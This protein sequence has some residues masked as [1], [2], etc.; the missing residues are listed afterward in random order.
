MRSLWPL[1]WRLRLACIESSAVPD[2]PNS[3]KQ[4]APQISALEPAAKL[5][6]HL[7]KTVLD[8]PTYKT[9]WEEMKNLYCLLYSSREM[10]ERCG[11]VEVVQPE[12]YPHP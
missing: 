12:G 11:G 5:G 3:Q 8:A 4:G 10:A 7:P 1:V 6:R 2:E 9:T